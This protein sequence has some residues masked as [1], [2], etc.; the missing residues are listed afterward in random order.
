MRRGQ[1]RE[2]NMTAPAKETRHE[3]ITVLL[4]SKVV[5]ELQRTH[6]R[7]D[8]STTDIVNRAITLYDFLDEERDS[9][10]ELLLRRR[11]GSTH[12]VELA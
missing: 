3:E 2:V 10:T 11:D 8:L 4:V 6:E 1:R 5:E 7:T 12:L 9:G